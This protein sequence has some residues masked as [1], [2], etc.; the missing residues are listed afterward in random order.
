M[1]H[2]DRWRRDVP[3]GLADRLWCLTGVSAKVDACAQVHVLSRDLFEAAFDDSSSAVA[4]RP[5]ERT[6][7]IS[8][9]ARMLASCAR[10]CRLIHRLRLRI[11]VLR[12]WAFPA[13]MGSVA[14]TGTGGSA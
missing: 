2:G 12:H 14:R 11:P 1:P 10:Q 8:A 13:S 5:E 6:T 4:V 7:M 3:V 9:A